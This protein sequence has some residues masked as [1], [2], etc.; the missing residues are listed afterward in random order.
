MSE[1]NEFKRNLKSKAQRVISDIAREKNETFSCADKLK[2]LIIEGLNILNSSGGFQN[3][4]GFVYDESKLEDLSIT[5][6]SIE[7]IET[8]LQRFVNT[9]EDETE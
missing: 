7:K 9:V 3:F 4:Y 1:L 5:N 2:T 6:D 8:A